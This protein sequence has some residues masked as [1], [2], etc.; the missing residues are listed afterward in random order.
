VH[1]DGCLVKAAAAE[2]W[3]KNNSL[4]AEKYQQLT[5]R[6]ARNGMITPSSTGIMA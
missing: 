5:W 1:V 3:R 4:K 6:E 2:G